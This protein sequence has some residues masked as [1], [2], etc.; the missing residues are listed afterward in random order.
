MGILC[1]CSAVISIPTGKSGVPLEVVRLF[2]KN[3]HLNCVLHLYFKQLGGKF[4]LN[5]KRTWYL[6]DCETM[7][8]FVAARR[9]ST[10]IKERCLCKTC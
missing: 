6:F 7:F 8:L 4:W 1:K 5:G 3:F 2:Q 9:G 10:I